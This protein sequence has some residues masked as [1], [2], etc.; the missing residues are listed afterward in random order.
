MSD[1]ETKK[2]EV[3]TAPKQAIRGPRGPGAGLGGAK[4][5]DAKVAALRFWSMMGGTRK[6]LVVTLLLSV[7]SVLASTIGPWQLG[8]ATDLLVSDHYSHMA[9]IRQLLIVAAI[10]LLASG[11]NLLQAWLMNDLMQKMGQNLR[12][13]AQ[14]KLSRVPLNWFDA[15]PH[16]EVLSRF[17]NDIDNMVQSLQQISSQAVMMS[18]TIVGV[19]FMMC[20]LSI[21]LALIAIGTIGVSILITGQI[22]K[23]ASPQFSEQW[24]Q[25]GHLNATIEESFTGQD[26]VRVFGARSRFEKRFEAQNNALF[27]ASLNAQ[28][29]ASLIQP[30]TVFVTNL[31]YIAVIVVGAF[32]VLG[33]DMS[34]GSLQAFIQYIRQI[35]QPVSQLGSMAAQIQSALASAERVFELLDAPEMAFEHKDKKLLTD[36]VKGHV[37]FDHVGFR[38]QQNKPLFEDVSLEAKPGQM[39]AIVGPTGAGKTTLVNLLMRFY[40]IDR[41]T[42]MLDGQDISKMSRNELRSTVAMVL[43]DTWL[44]TGTIFE[45]LSYG[46]TD[47]DRERVLEAARRCHV[48]DFVRTLPDGYDSVL[49]NAG[50]SLSQGQRQLMTIARAFLLDSPILILDEATS[51]VDTRTEMLIQQAMNELRQGRTS[52]VIAHR[53]STIRDAD[54]IVYMEEGNVL[55]TGTHNELMALKGGYWTLQRGGD[56][57]L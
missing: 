9:L 18:L 47:C 17:T 35:G 21:P 16:G 50:A 5:K 11:L 54:Q 24:K 8:L 23:R 25:T 39:L 15:Q 31:A 30:S 10:Y 20:M 13:Q 45:N 6:I 26:L 22:T 36:D 57:A 12:K 46:C 29:L 32:R 38:Y 56:V 42:I 19:L 40:E 27:K 2:L 28:I 37:L 51:S 52:F 43:Q 7:G 3:S 48:D 4:P 33:G 49:E 34:L 1:P 41:G 55:E 53:L 14:A 44:Y